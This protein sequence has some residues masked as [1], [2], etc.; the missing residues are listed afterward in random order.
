MYGPL[1]LPSGLS[2]FAHTA[3]DFVS[4]LFFR[5]SSAAQHTCDI[6]PPE[7]GSF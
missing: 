4:A 1:L 5:V 7:K 2:S 3:L 6:N